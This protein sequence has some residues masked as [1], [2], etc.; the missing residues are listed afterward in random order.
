[1]KLKILILICFFV[2]LIAG[3]TGPGENGNESGA[4]Q[5]TQPNSIPNSSTPTMSQP[6]N[7]TNSTADSQDKEFVEWLSIAKKEA[8]SNIEPI[9]VSIEDKNWTKLESTGRD[10]KNDSRQLL[11]QIDDHNVSQNMEE[12]REKYVE[13][14][15]DF[16]QAGSYYESA[17][18]NNSTEDLS[19]AQEH[20]KDA[21]NH[22]N[23][24]TALLN[25]KFHSLH[26]NQM[27][28]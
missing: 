25:D 27:L 8:M 13:S 6:G 20:L 28:Q 19:D 1:M 7:T 24:A 17:G 22:L 21:I 11:S 4:L 3:C 12:V 23:N 18:R 10:L 26:T 16:E 9:M 15:E 5:T 2:I 14:L